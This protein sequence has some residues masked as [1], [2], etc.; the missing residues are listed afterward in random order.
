[1]ADIKAIETVYNGYRFRSRLEARWAVFFDKAKIEYVYEP[2]GFVLS[3]NQC[4]L[5]DFYLPLFHMY[6]EIKPK[7][8]SE[9]DLNNAMGKLEKLFDGERF[10]TEGNGITVSLFRGDPLD[11]DMIVFCNYSDDE[12]GGQGWFP[13]LFVYG[14]CAEYNGEK[15]DLK[16]TLAVITQCSADDAFNN[17]GYDVHC[18]LV[19]GNDV[20]SFISKLDEEAA[21]ARMARFEH[22]ECG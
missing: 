11:K 6:V 9:D 16:E 14:V 22:G 12:G 10:C 5:P 19:N 15:F 1:M 18:R 3:D 21:Y 17:S 2:E 8:I 20:R 13:F 4:Y 7:G